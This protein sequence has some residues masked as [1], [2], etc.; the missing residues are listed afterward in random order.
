M[1]L[2]IIA[3]DSATFVELI[4]AEVLKDRF[5]RQYDWQTR[6]VRM[7]NTPEFLKESN[8]FLAQVQED[9][10]LWI[11]SAEMITRQFPCY[12][13]QSKTW[14]LVTYDQFPHIAKPF[15]QLTRTAPA[16]IS[17]PI[18]EAKIAWDPK[19]ITQ[20]VKPSNEEN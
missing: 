7:D 19:P 4:Y 8:T 15:P 2:C 14:S 20:Q 9:A 3:F 6:I 5:K 11:G 18:E 10:V 17:T 1:K 13:T 12:H 16:A